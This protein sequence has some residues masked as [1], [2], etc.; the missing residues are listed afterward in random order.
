VRALSAGAR[1]AGCV[2][3]LLK[4]GRPLVDPVAEDGVGHHG[5]MRGPGYDH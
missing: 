5:N 3:P 1:S 2:E 4:S